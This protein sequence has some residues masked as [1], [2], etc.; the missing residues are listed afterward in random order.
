MVGLPVKLTGQIKLLGVTR[1]VNLNFDA[2][3]ENVS[4]A[5]YFHIQALRQIRSSLMKDMANS[6]AC[7]VIQSSPDYTNAL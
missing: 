6:I 4:K 7:S 3:F 2:E 1:D 5:S